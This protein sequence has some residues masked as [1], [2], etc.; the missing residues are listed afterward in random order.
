MPSSATYRAGRTMPVK[1]SL[2]ICEA[3]DP[4]K[5]FVRNEELAIKIKKGDTVLQE[6]VSGVTATDYRIDDIGEHYITN[7]KTP[8]KPAMFTVEVWRI[9][10]NFLLGAFEFETVRK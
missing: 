2:R 4:A 9:R 5:P 1:F 10:A 7:F 6:S 8:K 3:V